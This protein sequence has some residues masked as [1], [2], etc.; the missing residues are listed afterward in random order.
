MRAFLIAAALVL[1]GCATLTDPLGIH[2]AEASLT[3]QC[4]A[5]GVAGHSDEAGYCWQE[6]RREKQLHAE[7]EAR[8]LGAYSPPPPPMTSYLN[9]PAL[10]APPAP[11]T[12]A[13]TI[14]LSHMY[15]RPAV[16]HGCAGYIPVNGPGLNPCPQ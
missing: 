5:L 16:P 14:D 8:L 1:S 9:V 12:P 2:R 4:T 6:L 7:Q 11:P 13:P 15:D 10:S 3:A